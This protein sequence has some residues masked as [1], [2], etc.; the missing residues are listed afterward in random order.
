MLLSLSSVVDRF[1]DARR[2]REIRCHAAARSAAV[3]ATA[4]ATVAAPVMNAKD[5][6]DD[7]DDD[8]TPVLF[9]PPF[10][11][12]STCTN[13]SFVIILS[14]SLSISVSLSFSL[15][16]PLPLFLLTSLALRVHHMD[17]SKG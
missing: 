9:K 11:L 8:M 15:S 16:L 4:P 1:V 3:P 10:R 14:F 5:D 13:P 12:I 2:W 6:D 7:D 17:T